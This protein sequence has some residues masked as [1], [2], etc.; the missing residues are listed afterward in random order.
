MAFCDKANG[1]CRFFPVGSVKI[2]DQDS[3]VAVII[4]NILTYDVSESV[5]AAPEVVDD[6]GVAQLGED[7]VAAFRAFDFLMA[8]FGTSA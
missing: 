2:D 5:V 8:R 1:V 6:H 4:E 3:C 7:A